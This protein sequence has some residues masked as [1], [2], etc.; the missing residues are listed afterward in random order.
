MLALCIAGC[1]SAPNDCYD[2]ENQD[3]SNN[4]LQ[5]HAKDS[6][7]ISNK[8]NI[9]ENFSTGNDEQYMPKAND[10]NKQNNKLDYSQKPDNIDLPF[11]NQNPSDDEILALYFQANLI[12]EMFENTYFNT[13]N[14]YIDL[15][16]FRYYKVIDDR[17]KSIADLERTLKTIFCDDI[18]EI[19]IGNGQYHEFESELYTIAADK[20]GNISVGDSVYE[21]IKDDTIKI[22]LRFTTEILDPGED[23][24]YSI[25]SG[26]RTHEMI[27]EYLDGKWLFT[28][29]YIIGYYDSFDEFIRMSLI[30]E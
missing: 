22:V 28:Q 21:I 30:D 14:S 5:E 26:Y 9:H 27:L 20:G 23:F 7:S 11:T 4:G 15:G 24:S 19:L 25:I 18:A 6:N 13:D 12:E 10:D 2:K 1:D 17:Y 8:E 3:N 16:G 29:F